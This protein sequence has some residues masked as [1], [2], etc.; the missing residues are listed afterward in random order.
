MMQIT[1][2]T[3]SPLG[4]R[5]RYRVLRGSPLPI[6]SPQSGAARPSA[7][8]APP[9]VVETFPPSGAT[10]IDST[11][12]ELRVMFSKPMQDG[13]WSWTVWNKENFPET[14][15]APRFLADGKTCVL[16]VKLKPGK[17]YATWLNSDSH[18][19]FADPEG[20]PA[21]PYLLIFETRK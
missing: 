7:A 2:L 14:T 8:T 3:P 11:L 19:D 10:D 17:L 21:V 18:K 6:A 4:A 9:V 16:P 12:T 15:G 1:E 5:I 13:R 20:R